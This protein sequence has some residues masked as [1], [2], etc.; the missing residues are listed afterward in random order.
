MKR[1]LILGASVRACAQSA[2]RAGLSV[3]ACDLFADRDTQEIADCH[4]IVDYPQGMLALRR[5]YTDLP[6]I[7]TGALENYP[8]LVDEMAGSGVLLGND[9][10]VIRRVRDPLYVQEI[11]REHGIRFPR[12]TVTPPQAPGAAWLRKR[13]RSAG[14]YQTEPYVAEHDLSS[15]AYF[16]EFISGE[17][18]S[19]TYIGSAGR[20]TMVGQTNMLVGLSWV[21]AAGFAYCGS[22]L[23]IAP[24][25][26]KR[27]WQQLGDVTAEEFKLQ[28]AFGIDAIVRDR[29]VYP[30]EINPRYTSSMEVLDVAGSSSIVSQHIRVWE[31]GC[32]YAEEPAEPRWNVAKVILFADQDFVV[33]PHLDT[34]RLPKVALAD[35]PMPGARI[36]SGDPIL[37]LIAK[38]DFSDDPLDLLRGAV[39][40]VKSQLGVV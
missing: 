39:D 7:Y 38:C 30:I 11:Y 16:Q 29:E 6:L 10:S 15:D 18:C 24:P 31:K 28:G 32:G 5:R 21:G 3:V 33:P 14:G 9:A 27:K 34:A 36:Q 22:R 12:T 4:R 35:I 17:V 37:T 40:R 25:D 1:V 26:E 20:A 2:A 19:A 13:Y 8:E 23:R